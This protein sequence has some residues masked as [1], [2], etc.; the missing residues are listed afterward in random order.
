[1]NKPAPPTWLVTW[2]EL[3]SMTAPVYDPKGNATEWTFRRKSDT[4]KFCFVH[5]WSFDEFVSSMEPYL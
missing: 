2:C 4:L 3:H 1:M 5:T